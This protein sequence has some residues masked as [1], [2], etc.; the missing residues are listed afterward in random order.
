MLLN[1][2]KI[3]PKFFRKFNILYIFK[4][5]LKRKIYCDECHKGSIILYDMKMRSKIQNWKRPVSLLLPL[6]KTIKINKIYYFTYNY[7]RKLLFGKMCRQNVFWCCGKRPGD[8]NRKCRSR[9]VEHTDAGWDQECRYIRFSPG[10][11]F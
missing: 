10:R 4:G 2:S 1:N 5:I 3:I 6:T 7:S 9:S 11:L 8:I